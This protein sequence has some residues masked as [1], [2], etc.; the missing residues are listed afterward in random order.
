MRSLDL[1]AG[2]QAVDPFGDIGSVPTNAKKGAKV[3]PILPDESTKEMV[4]R[5]YDAQQRKKSAAA[6]ETQIKSELGPMAKAYWFRHCRGKVSGHPS[7]IEVKSETRST[8]VTMKNAY[9]TVEAGSSTATSIQEILGGPQAMNEFMAVKTVLKIDASKIPAENAGAIGRI[10][11]RVF[12]AN[13]E[14]LGDILDVV[15]SFQVEGPGCPDAI[16]R[17]SIIEPREHF[18][19]VRHRDLSATQSRQLEAVFPCQVS[20]GAVK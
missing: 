5:L 19:S 17:T 1:E 6:T 8:K 9:P 2:S 14:E 15:E 3:Y 10:L 13:T 12:N 11:A 20:V 7:S 4:D 16:V 18:H